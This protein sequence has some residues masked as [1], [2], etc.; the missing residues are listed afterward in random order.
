MRSSVPVALSL[1]VAA[2]P[3]TAFVAAPDASLPEAVL[4]LPGAPPALVAAARAL[5]VPAL[6]AEVAALPGVAPG[7]QA[8]LARVAS[9][10]QDPTPERLL[11]F[12][13]GQRLGTTLRNPALAAQP[14][15]EAL[16]D[17]HAEAGVAPDAAALAAIGA[18][19]AL[20]PAAQE[21]LAGM[22]T[23]EVYALRQVRAAYA[24]LAP[25]EL[26]VLRLPGAGEALQG[27]VRWDLL[28]LAHR[29][30][31]A[32]VEAALPALAALAPQA[33]VLSTCDVVLINLGATDD[34]Y[35]CDHLL[36]V[37]LAGSDTYRN[38]AGGTGMGGLPNAAMA[39]DVAGNDAYVPVM[40]RDGATI[41]A[42][43]Y[44]SGVLYDLA[45]H[46]LYQPTIIPLPSFGP[47]GAAVG[48]GVE[49]VGL[50]VDHDGS[51]T[52]IVEGLWYAAAI[53][54]GRSG[55]GVLLD[56]GTGDDVRIADLDAAGGA[57]GGADRGSGFLVD[58][59]GR[60]V[61]HGML[62]TRVGVEGGFNGGAMIGHAALLDYGAGDDTYFAELMGAAMGSGGANGG[63][64][65]LR[66]LGVLVDQGGH[67]TYD[68]P[69][70][71]MDSAANGAGAA[72][73]VGV[74]LDLAGNDAF[75]G[76]ADMTGAVNGAA[77]ASVGVLVNVG[78]SD[79]Y[80]ALFCNPGTGGVNGG[81]WA[82]TGL[83]LDLGGIDRYRERVEH[84]HH[85][86]MAEGPHELMCM[87]MMGMGV[88]SEAG[89]EAPWRRDT[90]QLA[91]G[92]GEPINVPTGAQVDDSLGQ[93]LPPSPVGLTGPVEGH[94]LRMWVPSE[95]VVRMQVEGLG[96]GTLP[97]TSYKPHG[98]VVLRGIQ[99]FTAANGV[100]GGRGTP[101]DPFVISGWA[102]TGAHTGTGL[103]LEGTDLHVVVR[104]NLFIEALDH[105]IRLKGA[106][107]V[108]LE[109]NLCA[110]AVECI[111]LTHGS[112]ALLRNNFVTRAGFG[113]ATY[114][115]SVR[116]E[117]NDIVSNAEG[118][119]MQRSHIV[120][121]GNEFVGN[122]DS[123]IGRSG[124]LVLQDNNFRFSGGKSFNMRNAIMVTDVAPFDVCMN[125]WSHPSG[126]MLMPFEPMGP[127]LD[128][129][130][131]HLVHWAEHMLMM[132]HPYG[133]EMIM[134]VPFPDCWDPWLTSPAPKAGWLL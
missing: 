17:L 1:L 33:T 46:D 53:G 112:D 95:G 134:S 114:D 36:S 60:D 96:S 116:L 28:F 48:A 91:K 89:S 78:G 16:L 70:G 55:H 127:P 61:Y 34:T 108:V 49:G 97:A 3:A 6:L 121:E 56:R 102:F 117:R 86:M 18:L 24:A 20:P 43:L 50:L 68:F 80:D 52:A 44:G 64:S 81:A 4:P 119:Y 8:A 31:V 109:R 19:E 75:R 79:S 73:G 9:A 47:V 30:Q 54:G 93:T 38:N 113:I 62:D 124:S 115:S 123:I 120:G 32:A 41:G 15:R 100:K 35:D 125:W 13:E 126:P 29:A 94:D 84:H 69:M 22:A 122:R 7:E 23:A 98:P 87:M 128:G 40:D 2:L 37:D 12:A 103:L 59:G 5:H 106:R 77:D 107:N 105:G 65:G 66:T 82:G 72:G 118:I 58:L 130:P 92:I 129:D 104:D 63:A 132:A 76:M 133:G 21:A 88:S 45:G 74:L 26:E 90:V 42:A 51:D 27:K 83:L 67:D 110:L 101:E 71:M 85:P 10:W 39:L 131:D 111:T 14:L 99:D 11:A 57:L 25:L